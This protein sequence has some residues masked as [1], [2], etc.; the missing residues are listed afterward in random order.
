MLSGSQQV[1]KI[2]EDEIESLKSQG[3][4]SER[5]EAYIKGLEHSL[6]VIKVTC[7]DSCA[8]NPN[9]NKSV[10]NPIPFFPQAPVVQVYG[11]TVPADTW[12]FDNSLVTNDTITINTTPVDITVPADVITKL[13]PSGLSCT[14]TEKKEDN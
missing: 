1:V 6:M 12:A 4:L 3:D 10:R 2:L 13:T 5:L 11:C 9:D 14:N 7:K 8:D